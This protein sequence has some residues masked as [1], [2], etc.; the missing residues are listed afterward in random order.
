MAV[1]FIDGENRGYPKKTSDM[2][3][4]TDKLYHIMLYPVN[5]AMSGI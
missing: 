3:K 4:V 5:L 1:S 2:S